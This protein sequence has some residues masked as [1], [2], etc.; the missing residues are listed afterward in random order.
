MMPMPLAG[1]VVDGAIHTG[2]DGTPTVSFSCPFYNDKQLLM[3][4]L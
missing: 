4:Y 3:F 1:D 2:P